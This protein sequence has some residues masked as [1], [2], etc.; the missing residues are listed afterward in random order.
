MAQ[1]HRLT[2]PS[3][4]ANNFTRFYRNSSRISQCRRFDKPSHYVQFDAFYYDDDAKWTK[5]GT[6]IDRL[7]NHLLA[8]DDFFLGSVLI[9]A[10]LKS[11]AKSRVVI[12]GLSGVFF[13]DN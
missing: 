5:G 8:T 2:I 4:F 12:F 11:I 7:G 6:L 10:I 9:D 1:S 3:I 13:S